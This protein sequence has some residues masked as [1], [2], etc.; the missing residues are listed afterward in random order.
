VDE[1]G[2]DVGQSETK[3]LVF[4]VRPVLKRFN[5]MRLLIPDFVAILP[6]RVYSGEWYGVCFS[7]DALR[8]QRRATAG[9]PLTV[10]RQLRESV[11]VGFLLPGD[12][13][14]WFYQERSEPGDAPR[15]NK[16]AVDRFVAEQD[17]TSATTTRYKV[18]GEVHPS[19]L[20]SPADRR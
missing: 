19:L 7:R 5:L 18:H 16:V 20:R 9:A 4:L 13:R 15:L 1:F 12:E 14:P 17:E 3:P 8:G 6:A 2:L 10:R 11:V